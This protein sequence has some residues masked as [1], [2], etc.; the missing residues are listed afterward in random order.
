MQI[1][2]SASVS[3][4]AWLRARPPLRRG[5]RL[6]A[7]PPPNLEDRCNTYQPTHQPK[8][9]Q[10]QHR[11]D[12]LLLLLFA[13]QSQ[14]MRTSE[15]DRMITKVDGQDDLLT[16]GEAA[17]ILGS[18]RQH[19]GNLIKRGDITSTLV[20]KHHRVRRADVEMLKQGSIRLTRDQ[21]RSLWLGYAI[22]GK[23]V[24]DPNAAIALAQRNIDTM[25]LTQRGSG[26]R[27]LTRWRD[28]LDGSTEAILATLTSNSITARELRQ[29][30][31]FAGLLDDATR[32][33]VITAT[34]NRKS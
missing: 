31:P 4:I 11:C 23:I 6:R 2:A 28:L 15:A 19:V 27:W 20:G 26:R 16:T 12:L 34:G 22:A 1:G 18:T 25:L 32:L 33:Q 17:A 10:R 9:Q 8:Q 29:N 30:N 3:P 14:G 5:A 13:E 21:R 7:P 24:T